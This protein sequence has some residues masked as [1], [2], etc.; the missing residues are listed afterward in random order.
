MIERWCDQM[1]VPF[2]SQRSDGRSLEF[3]DQE[4]KNK[5]IKINNPFRWALSI[6]SRCRV[7]FEPRHSH[8][9]TKSVRISQN[10]Y[11]FSIGPYR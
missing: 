6:Q 4:N 9:S 5:N 11:S 7:C 10:V 3:P 1:G 2:G 8:H